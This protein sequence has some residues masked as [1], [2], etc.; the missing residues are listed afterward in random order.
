LNSIKNITHKDFEEAF[1]EE[2]DSFTISKIKE[3][4]FSYSE[5]NSIEKDE[6]FL[7][8]LKTLDSSDVKKSGAHRK[9]DWELGWNENL[10]EF[11]KNIN[12]LSLIPKY[13]G[14]FPYVR[15]KKQFVKPINL[16]FEYNMA[17]VLQYWLFTKYFSDIDNVYEFGCGTGHNLIRVNEINSTVKLYGLDWVDTSQNILKIIN[18]QLGIKIYGDKFNFFDIDKEFKLIENAGIFTFAALE[19]LSDHYDDFIQYLIEQ[20]PKVCVHIEPM[21]EYLD[22]NNLNDYLSL[23]YFEKRNYIKDFRKYMLGLESLGKIEIL[24]NQRSN[25]G[26]MFV[27]GYSIL[28][29][30]VKNV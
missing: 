9:N 19:Q 25:I 28:V 2:L 22:F 16:E 13:F 29:W 10:M 12:L 4:N 11:S 1:G 27:D 26:S 30:R 8:I 6:L 17:K 15:W 20:N 3:Y 23:K 21:G 7:T 24:Q 14:K 5:L 18:E